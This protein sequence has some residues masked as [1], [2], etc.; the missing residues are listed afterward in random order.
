CRYSPLSP[1]TTLFRS[2]I[3]HVEQG[4]GEGGSEIVDGARALH[5]GHGGDARLPVGGDSEDGRWLGDGGGDRL[6]GAGGLVGLQRP[7][8]ARSEEHTSEL[9]SHLKL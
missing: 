9:Q 5:G 8:R 7:H 1:Y 3:L 2:R 4:L 6:P